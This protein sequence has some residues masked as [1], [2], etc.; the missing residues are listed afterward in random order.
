LPNGNHFELIIFSFINL[1]NFDSLGRDTDDDD[2]AIVTLADLLFNAIVCLFFNKNF[3]I[4]GQQNKVKLISNYPIL[5]ATREKKMTRF[6]RIK[7]L[8]T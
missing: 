4:S 6:N 5:R 3:K 7:N 8:I 2:D 1:L